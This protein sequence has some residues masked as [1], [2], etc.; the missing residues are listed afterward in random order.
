MNREL[1]REWFDKAEEDFG[2]AAKTLS[3]PD[4][5]Y[6]AQICFHF[7]QAAE[8]YLKAYIVAFDLSF[9][10]IHDLPE[11]LKICISQKPELGQAMEA[12]EFLTD[13]YIDT[14]YPVHWPSQITKEE[15]EKALKAAQKIKQLIQK[16][17]S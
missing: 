11:L 14:R 7:Q 6:Y 17:I 2:F 9:K 8:K 10:K 5:T 3:D 4:I 16:F 12:C 15:A 13:F 1:A